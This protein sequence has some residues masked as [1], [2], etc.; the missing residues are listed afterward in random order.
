MKPSLVVL[1]ILAFNFSIFFPLSL[2]AAMDLPKCK[3]FNS[4]S[5]TL[6]T[7]YEYRQS[8][9][10]RVKLKVNTFQFISESIIFVPLTS[11]NLQKEPILWD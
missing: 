5:L 3:S 1:S 6:K 8:G 4:K 9:I 11:K 2:N 7:T 10:T